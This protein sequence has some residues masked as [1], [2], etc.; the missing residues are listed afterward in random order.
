MKI[1]K[2]NKIINN[3][4]KTL[5]GFSELKTTNHIGQKP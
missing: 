3:K 1:N 5:T 4:L 2:K